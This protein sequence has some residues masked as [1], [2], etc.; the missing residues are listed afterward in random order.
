MAM[1]FNLA[2]RNFQSMARQEVPLVHITTSIGEDSIVH[3]GES[4][5]VSPCDSEADTFGCPN[6]TC[7]LPAEAFCSYARRRLRAF[8]D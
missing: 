3:A 5:Q 2:V 8:I 6:V 7:F 1:L 4:V